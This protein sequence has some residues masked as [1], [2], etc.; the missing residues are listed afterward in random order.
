M[1]HPRTTDL[2]TDSGEPHTLS[3]APKHAVYPVD[4]ATVDTTYFTNEP[5]VN[6][7]GEAFQANKP[8]K[9]LGIPS[10]YRSPELFLEQDYSSSIGFGSD[11]WALGCT[12]FEIRTG[13]K[14]FESFDDQDDEYLM[15]M[16]DILGPMPEPWWSTT[17]TARKR[18][19][20]DEA[21]SLGHAIDVN[22]PP[23]PQEI[24]DPDLDYQVTV[25]PS[26]VEGARSLM[27]KLAPGVW[28][29][30]MDEKD[31]KAHRDISD[32][33]KELFADLIGRFLKWKP[34]ERISAEEALKHEWFNM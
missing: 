24:Q 25:H 2:V 21:D 4:W 7:L 6:D 9:Y 28:Y 20:K 34:D 22:P 23:P 33:E 14:L 10:I 13:R 8:P 32:K 18:F 3:T 16:V 12:L 26:V 30:D 1:G 17:W 29:I 5:Q 19:Y 31:P 11:L 27:E 15:G